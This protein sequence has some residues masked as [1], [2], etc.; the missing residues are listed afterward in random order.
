MAATFG[1]LEKYSGGKQPVASRLR[2]FSLGFGN[3]LAKW[4]KRWCV[5][6]EGCASSPATNL[7]SLLLVGADRSRGPT[8][9]PL[10]SDRSPRA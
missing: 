6:R 7:P 2:R 1:Y 10:P 9:L 5:L 8:M 4:D 3:A